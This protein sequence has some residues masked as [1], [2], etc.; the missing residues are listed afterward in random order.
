MTHD[1]IDQAKLSHVIYLGVD[2]DMKA[3]RAIT[4]RILIG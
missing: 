2:E 1:P 4:W 3:L